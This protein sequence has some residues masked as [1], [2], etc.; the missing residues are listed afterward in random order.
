MGHINT[1]QIEQIVCKSRSEAL[2]LWSSE[3]PV[4]VA[5]EY[6]P[7]I[8]SVIYTQM[9]C[10]PVAVSAPRRSELEGTSDE[11]RSTMV[12][13]KY[14]SSLITMLGIFIQLKQ[15][16]KNESLFDTSYPTIV[17]LMVAI[18]AYGGS[19]IG[20]RGPNSCLAESIINKISLL[21]GTLA[22]VLESFR[23]SSR[24]ALGCLVCESCTK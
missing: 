23:A 11:E 22:V 18:L 2:K 1:N 9:D 17:S 3:V 24:I 14:I 19:L 7:A 12:L 16:A 8:L 5:F 21:L 6:L 20:F 13:H 15:G 10:V 4:T